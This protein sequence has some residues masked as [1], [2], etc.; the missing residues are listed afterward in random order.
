MGHFP[1]QTV[2]HNQRAIFFLLE[3]SLNLHWRRIFDGF[4]WDDRND[5]NGHRMVIAGVLGK[6]LHGREF[7]SGPW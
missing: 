1:W 7:P 2:S 6:N 4:L 5:S 3:G